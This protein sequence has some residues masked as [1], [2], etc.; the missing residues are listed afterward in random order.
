MRRPEPAGPSAA[1]GDEPPGQLA[2]TAVIHDMYPRRAGLPALFA[3]VP[4]Q[5][6]GSAAGI[7]NRSKFGY[8]LSDYTSQVIGRI[9]NFLAHISVLGERAKGVRGRLLCARSNPPA[10]DPAGA[11]V[12]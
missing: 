3:L 5:P 4:R 2:K 9:R 11:L 12:G 8:R 6:V 1:A 7:S 10:R